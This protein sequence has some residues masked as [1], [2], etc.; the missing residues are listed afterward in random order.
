[1]LAY[2]PVSEIPAPLQA[3]GVGSLIGLHFARKPVLTLAQ[4]HPHDPAAEKALN[5]L[6][7]LLHL[8]L[9][10]RGYYIARRG[11][12]ALSLPTNEADAQGFVSALSDILETHR[13]LI[14]RSLPAGL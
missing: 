7:K 11:F 6:H 13:A 4:A 12:M 9:I 3:T 1:M 2:L 8:E 5:D 10:Q 14:E